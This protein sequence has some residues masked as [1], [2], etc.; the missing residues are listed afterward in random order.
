MRKKRIFNLVTII[1]FFLVFFTLVYFYGSN[2]TGYIISDELGGIGSKEDINE[3]DGIGFQEEQIEIPVQEKIEEEIIIAPEIEEKEVNQDEINKIEVE[4]KTFIFGNIEILTPPTHTRPYLNSTSP[5]NRTRDNLTVYNMSVSDDNSDPVNLIYDWRVNLNSIAVLNIPC[6]NSTLNGSFVTDYSTNSIN[7]TFLGNEFNY[8]TSYSGFSACY[9]D[10]LDEN[11][12]FGDHNYFDINYNFTIEFWINRSE[13]N[14]VDQGIVHRWMASGNNRAFGIRLHNSSI[15]VVVSKDG[16]YDSG[17]YFYLNASYNITPNRFY[18]V[19]VIYNDTTMS[20][21][22]DGLRKKMGTW[23]KGIASVNA[24]LYVG[25]DT[26]GRH[27]NGS[28][29]HFIIYNRP[30][31]GFEI[32]LHNQSK[33]EIIHPSL[34]GP[35]QNWSCAITPNDGNSDGQTIESNGVN[36]TYIG[37]GISYN[38]T[39]TNNNATGVNYYNFTVRIE[40]NISNLANITYEM[41]DSYSLNITRYNLT[42]GVDQNFTHFW[43]ITN[44]TGE[45]Y[46]Y[47]VTLTTMYNDIYRGTNLMIYGDNIS[48]WVNITD[49]REGQWLAGTV[50]DLAGNISDNESGIASCVWRFQNS[51]GNYS[52]SCNNTDKYFNQTI[53]TSSIDSW[54]RVF[55]YVTDKAGNIGFTNVTFF[56]TTKAAIIEKLIE[57]GRI[58]PPSEETEETP[59][60]TIEAEEETVVIDVPT[61]VFDLIG[62]PLHLIEPIKL[63]YVEGEIR[64]DGIFLNLGGKGSIKVSLW[65]QFPGV[66]FGFTSEELKGALYKIK[67][68]FLT[69]YFLLIGFMLVIIFLLVFKYILRD[70]Y[71]QNKYKFIDDLH[72]L[73]CKLLIKFSF[74]R[75]LVRNTGLQKYNLIIEEIHDLNSYIRKY[76]LKNKPI[77]RY[78]NL[79]NLYNRFSIYMNKYQNR[80]IF[81]SLRLSYERIKLL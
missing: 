13:P 43:Y 63:D 4:N 65:E 37:S 5:F 67:D 15:S 81:E 55:V 80:A 21:F 32:E 16:T 19:A 38:S 39:L 27:F 50:T 48:P 20:I 2:I 66:G 70:I 44:L 14:D 54:H 8:T 62:I 1:L 78:N 28:I 60:T 31:S 56:R 47:N 12:S 68:I 9:F 73:I 51:E 53:T 10:G 3:L 25:V 76:R 42:D 72:K 41:R 26:L 35:Y 77:I 75:K 17:S 33:Y 69:P 7:G 6:Q 11:I 23:S 45:I 61:K 29:V 22:I 74:G 59:E 71:T 36:I 64:D 30:L 52:L 58:S 40:N 18:H 24:P 57:T 34:I 49:P 79:N 46:Y